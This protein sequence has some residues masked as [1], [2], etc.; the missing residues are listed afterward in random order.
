[1]ANTT[2][3]IIVG[4]AALYISTRDSGSTDPAHYDA[5]G[6]FIPAP[7]PTMTPSTSVVSALDA[8]PNWRGVGFTDTGITLSYEPT[9]ADVVVD[10]LLDSAK[11]FKSSMRVTLAT[12]FVE[13]ALK[14]LLVVWGQTNSTLSST[15]TEDV[16][17]IASGSLG[18]DPV[19]RALVAVGPAPKSVAGVKRERVY[20]TRRVLSVDTTAHSVRR[21]E[22]TVFPV[23]FRLL[24]MSPNSA[25]GVTA[26]QEYGIIRDRNV[27][28]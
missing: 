23:T 2:R 13:A 5:N 3:N 4:A 10:Q 22:A 16:L 12:T 28:A 7:T 9:Y 26:G 11:V 27:A 14:N 8:D 6:D 17:G 24:P 19:E 25:N 18:D 1:M 21:A 15:A 20:Y